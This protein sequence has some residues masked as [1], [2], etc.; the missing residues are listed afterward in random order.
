[1]LKTLESLGLKQLDAEVYVYLAKNEPQK[2]RDISEALETYKRQLYHSLRNLQLKGMVSASQERPARFSAIS[3]DK[4]LD[5]FIQ[6]NREEAQ[7]IE[8]NKEQILSIW[9]SKILGDF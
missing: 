2:A 8:E 7:G 6:A 4:V 9:R 1:M 3:F 5:Q